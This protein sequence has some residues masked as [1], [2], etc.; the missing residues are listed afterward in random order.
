MKHASQKTLASL[1]KLLS[2]IRLLP[3]ITEKKTGIFYKSGKAFLHFHEDPAGIF[4][5]A[6]VEGHDF[7]RFSVNSEDEVT[8]FL[9]VL[10]E[11]LA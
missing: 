7:N 1:D 2:E 5:D 10:R 4:A 8:V 3:R 11:K 9:G 6:R